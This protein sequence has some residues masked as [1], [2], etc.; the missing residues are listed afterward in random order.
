MAQESSPR[1][2]VPCASTVWARGFPIP[3]GILR[4]TWSRAEPPP[5]PLAQVG[6][7]WLQCGQAGGLLGWDTSISSVI[8]PRTQGHPG[9]LVPPTFLLPGI[10]HFLQGPI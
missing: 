1:E 10:H 7:E 2:M 3:I 4:H 8:L 9:L 5:E 6:R